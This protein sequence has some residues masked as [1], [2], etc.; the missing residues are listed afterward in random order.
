MRLCFLIERQYAPYTKW[1]GTAFSRLAC[2][3]DL[4]PVLW[5]VL[6]AE[7][8]QQREDALLSA[9]ALVVASH[10]ALHVTGPV[11]TRMEQ[12]WD[13]PFTVLWGDFPP[14]LLEQIQ[15]PEVRRIAQRWPVGGVDRLR[16]LP[17]GDGTRSVLRGLL[18]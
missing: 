10:E 18:D 3:G 17:G 6:R 14:A 11:T 2:A 4:S 8:W 16:D 1:Y 12:L 5:S 7:T 13:R 9:Y 15:D